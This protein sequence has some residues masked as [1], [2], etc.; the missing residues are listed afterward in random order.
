[1]YNLFEE[2]LKAV[3]D[4]NAFKGVNL[5]E[6]NL[7]P[8]LVMPPGFKTPKFEKYDEST[9][10]EMHLVMYCNKMVGHT[11][12]EKLLIHIF[13]ESLTETALKWYLKLRRGQIRTWR[14][15]A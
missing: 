8:D 3:E 14:D 9:C 7:A 5:D 2:R 10:P 4:R 15:L 13:Q 11:H 12:N 1:M 6:L